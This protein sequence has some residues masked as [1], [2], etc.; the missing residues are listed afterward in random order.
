M[1]NDR[2]NFVALAGC[3]LPTLSL[4]ISIQVSVAPRI[5]LAPVVRQA[6]CL[7][8]AQRHEV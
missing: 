4:P 1:E 5:H 2:L 3:C 7:G 8:S 6:Q